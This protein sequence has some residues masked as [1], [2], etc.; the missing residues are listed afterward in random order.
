MTLQREDRWTTAR[1]KFFEAVYSLV[2]SNKSL[3]R[4]LTY[5]ALGLVQ[6]SPD[7]LPEHMRADFKQF[8]HELTKTPL[9]EDY[10]DAPREVTPREARRIAIKILEM[11]TELLGGL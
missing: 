4:R 9:S 10:R 3:S 2:D 11:Y 5:A 8:M 6:L 7:D 1:Q